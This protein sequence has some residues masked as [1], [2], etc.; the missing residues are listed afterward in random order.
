M[1]KRVKN[2]FGK[3]VKVDDEG[4]LLKPIRITVGLEEIIDTNFEGF[5]DLISE[6]AGFELMMEQAFAVVGA[7]QGNVLIEVHGNVSEYPRE[8]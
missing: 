5:L 7:K 8:A 4:W 2:D 1:T 3:W 6:R